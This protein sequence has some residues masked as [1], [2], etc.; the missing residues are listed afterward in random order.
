MRLKYALAATM[1]ALALAPTAALASSDGPPLTESTS[2]CDAF[3][4]GLACIPPIDEDDL[5]HHIGEPS[6]PGGPSEPN[7][8]DQPNAV[9]TARVNVTG[10]TVLGQLTNLKPCPGTAGFNQGK[11]TMLQAGCNHAQDVIRL[12]Y[13]VVSGGTTLRP[14]IGE[15]VRG[16]A[17]VLTRSL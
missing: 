6:V 10:A 4:G 14:E 11:L 16:G 13:T 17:V 3:P 7:I 15:C 12:R 1:A 8:P 5:P 2:N 9:C